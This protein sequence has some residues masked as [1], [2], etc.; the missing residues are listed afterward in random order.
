MPNSGKSITGRREVIARGTASVI[1]QIAINIAMAKV[2]V[3]SG[4]PGSRSPNIIIR[5]KI[6]MPATNPICESL[7][8]FNSENNLN[9]NIQ[10]FSRC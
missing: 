6:R 3:I 10:F 7:L 1:H 2:K 9:T 5:R 8:F 4:F